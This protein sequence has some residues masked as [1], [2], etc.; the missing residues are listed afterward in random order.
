M[1]ELEK[2]CSLVAEAAKENRRAARALV[3]TILNRLNEIVS[4]FFLSLPP[5]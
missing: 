4:I 5:F 1:I 3:S 2:G